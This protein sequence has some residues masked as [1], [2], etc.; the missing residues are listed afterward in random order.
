MADNDT[1]PSASPTGLP[2]GV[3]EP[4]KL[5][6]GTFALLVQGMLL[7]LVVLLL[8][9]KRVREKPQR[10]CKVWL[11]DSSKQGCSA[12]CAHFVGMFVSVQLGKLTSADQECGWYIITYLVDT[13]VGVTCALTLLR[14]LEGYAS[15]RDE[16]D[17]IH[18]NKGA[19][20]STF[21]DLGIDLPE[22]DTE[23]WCCGCCVC[24][25]GKRPWMPFKKSG[26][27]IDYNLDPVNDP[28]D[29]PACRIWIRQLLA[30]VCCVI[31]GRSVCAGI[32]ILAHNLLQFI[33]DAICDAFDGHPKMF[34][35][36]VMVAGP[37]VLNLIQVWV[38]DNFLGK[39]VKQKKQ[40]DDDNDGKDLSPRGSPQASRKPPGLYPSVKPSESPRGVRKVLST[41]QEKDNPAMGEPFMAS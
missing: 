19:V 24:C 6:A 31:T 5:A 8:I 9:L 18:E 25:R 22:R 23:A 14:V 7:C 33:V 11:M 21:D 30:W 10:P 12:T 16:L 2:T 20:K 4:C 41:T 39:L 15:M 36:T 28:R 3:E 32:L 1:V 27:Y 35:I 13:S 37:G 38:Q 26:V 29:A 34:L 40:A 17:Q